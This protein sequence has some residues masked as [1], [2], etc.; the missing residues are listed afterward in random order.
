[1]KRQKTVVYGDVVTA[2]R[3]MKNGSVEQINCPRLVADYN[4]HMG[5]VDK[6]DMLK[7]CYAIDRKIK[8]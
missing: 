5:S 3:R 4:Q 1:M 8:K 6:A 2:N 7:K